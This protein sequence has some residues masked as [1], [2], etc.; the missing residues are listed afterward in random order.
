M[1][2][3]GIPEDSYDLE[4]QVDSTLTYLENRK[5]V[6]IELNLLTKSLFKD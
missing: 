1:K 3:K 5:N 6:M 4:A 2:R